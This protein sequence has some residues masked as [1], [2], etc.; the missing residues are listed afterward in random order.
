M[1]ILINQGKCV[2]FTETDRKPLDCL[3]EEHKSGSLWSF[4][5]GW[6]AVKAREEA[7]RATALAQESNDGGLLHG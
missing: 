1:E 7:E 3:N 2:I 6:I 5:G 4:Y